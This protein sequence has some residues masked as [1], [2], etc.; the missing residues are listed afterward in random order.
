M[1]GMRDP[2]AALD[3]YVRVE[4]PRAAQA[5]I[6]ENEVRF[7]ELNRHLRMSSCLVALTTQHSARLKRAQ[8]IQ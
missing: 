5:A 1:A 8:A 3:C 4:Q 7:L 2:A 6:L